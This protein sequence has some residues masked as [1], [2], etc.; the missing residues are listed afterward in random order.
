[1]P[2]IPKCG[3]LSNLLTDASHNIYVEKLEFTVNLKHK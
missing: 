3:N 2:Y 1:M